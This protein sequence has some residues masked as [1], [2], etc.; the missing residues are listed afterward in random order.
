MV[1][2]SR[3]FSTAQISNKKHTRYSSGLS[4]IVGTILLLSICIALISVVYTIVFQM[5]HQYDSAQTPTVHIAGSIVGNKVVLEHQ[6]GTSLRPDTMIKILLPVNSPDPV[7]LSQIK[8]SSSFSFNDLNNN[9]LWDIGEQIIYTHSTVLFNIQVEA[10]VFD[11]KSNTMIMRGVL[12]EGETGDSPYVVTLSCQNPQTY[13]ASI[14]MYYHFIS[15]RLCEDTSPPNVN[16]RWKKQTDS[17]WNDENW[18]AAPRTDNNPHG[19]GCPEPIGGIYTKALDNLESDTIYVFQARIQ[20][21]DVLKEGAVLS[22]RTL[23]TKAGEWLFDSFSADGQTVYDTSPYQNHGQLKQNAFLGPQK[24]DMSATDTALVFDGIDD[25]VEV[26]GFSAI[27]DQITIETWIKPGEYFNEKKPTIQKISDASFYDLFYDCVEPDVIHISDDTVNNLQVYAVV[28]R[29][30]YNPYGYISTIKIA[31]NGAIQQFNYFNTSYDLYQFEATN[32]KNPKIIHVSANYYAIVY[33]G[34]NNKGRIKTI[35]IQPDGTIIKSIRKEYL[36][37]TGTNCFEPDIIKVTPLLYAVVYSDSSYY[38]RVHTC[39]ISPDAQTIT[40]KHTF[41][42]FILGSNPVEYRIMKE[43]EIIPLQNPY[44]YA[45]V[46]TDKDNDGGLRT[47]SIDPDTGVVESLSLNVKFDTADGR[48]PEIIHVADNYY[49]IVY[50]G[51]KSG[52]TGKIIGY[53][54]T[55]MIPANGILQDMQFFEARASFILESASDKFFSP[56]IIK[57]TTSANVFLI[58]YKG[59]SDLTL[60]LKT[61]EIPSTANSI[62]LKDTVIF[63]RTGSFFTGY[64]PQILPVYNQVYMVLYSQGYADGS[65]PSNW[66]PTDGV[67]KTMTITA[68]GLIDDRAPVISAFELGH[69]NILEPLSV[70]ITDNLYAVAYK[71]LDYGGHLATI[72]ITP[73]GQITNHILDRYIFLH[74]KYSNAII[75]NKQECNYLNIVVVQDNILAVFYTGADAYFFVSTFSINQES[76]AITLITTYQFGISAYFAN[77]YRL[78]NRSNP[79]LYAVTYTDSNN[80]GVIIT[81]SI[82]S[83]GNTITQKQSLIFYQQNSP[84]YAMYT[85]ITTINLESNIY[86][87]AFQRYNT[88]SYS[89][90]ILLSTIHISPDGTTLQLINNPVIIENSSGYPS[91][92]Q[93]QPIDQNNDFLADDNCYVVVYRG[94][95]NSLS[96]GSIRTVN[97]SNTGKINGVVDYMRYKESCLDPKIRYI[98]QRMYLVGTAWSGLYTFRMSTKGHITDSTDFTKSIDTYYTYTLDIIDIDRTAGSYR[99]AVIYSGG[100][101]TSIDFRIQTIQIIESPFKQTILSKAGQYSHTGSFKI[102]ADTLTVSATMYFSDRSP[103]TLQQTILQ[104]CMNFIKVTYSKDSGEMKLYVNNNPAVS[105]FVGSNRLINQTSDT[106]IFGRYN[107]V[108][109]NVRIYAEVRDSPTEPYTPC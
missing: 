58:V 65:T 13:S 51:P 94:G 34:P 109:N 27:T 45:I 29:G 47:I 19:P 84:F 30:G 63:G 103:V 93:I 16:L 88:L 85:S 3:Y 108:Y 92:L 75:Q 48:Y 20:Y 71:G 61:V 101:G 69:V 46:F 23:S 37:D 7:Q 28:S 98:G 24:H 79:S 87:I 96:A 4:N 52:E 64:T 86:A 43:P 66:R 59:G 76:G 41:S 83:N 44:I 91:R 12:Q 77:V 89:C 26:S 57:H 39:T 67:V 32:C 10:E 81:L 74:G 8:D 73:E 35:E 22:F 25:T 82:S 70:K 42:E 15:S 99:F 53:C 55:I 100:P 18:V 2:K 36:F 106:L 49:C 5:S 102:E 6:G 105:F 50:G 14:S 97:I 68:Q 38:G 9:G 31:N 90:N 56:K 78:P 17:N 95:P 21:E 80:N 33:T 1:V 11:R 104:N 107:G 62:T 54:K 40:S 72:K 60:Y